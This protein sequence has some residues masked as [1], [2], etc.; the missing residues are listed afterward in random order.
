MTQLTLGMNREGIE[1]IFY[2]YRH[3]Q[4]IQWVYAPVCILVQEDQDLLL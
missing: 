2:T 3:R 4:A 1:S